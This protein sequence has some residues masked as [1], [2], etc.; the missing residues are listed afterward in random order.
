MS[1]IPDFLA[2]AGWGAARRAPLAG[3]ASARRYERLH[4]DG[5]SAV[6]MV[7]PPGAEFRRFAEIDDWLRAR[8]Y[9][10]PE[11]LAMEADAGLMLLEDLGDDLL[12]ALLTRSPAREAE[13]YGHVTDF[14]LDLHRHAPPGFVA[15]LDGPALGALVA[16]TADWAPGDPAAAAALPG[17]IAD[18]FAAQEALAPVLCLR[19][20]HAQNALWLPQRLGSARLGLLDFQDAVAGHP[21]YDLVSALQDVRRDVSPKVEALAR[22]AYCAARGLDPLSFGAAYALLGAQR[23]LR[24]H[25]V[26]ARLCLAMGKAAYVDLMPRNWRNLERN[27]AHP[28][29][30]V[31]AR[32]IRAA[33]P[34]PDA[35]M[36]EGLKRACGTRPTL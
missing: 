26:F 23:A 16:L 20:F 17:Q 30:A 8:G 12:S 31:L 13:L 28:A 18:L 22:Q 34:P 3:D 6:L 35:S 33:Y 2:Q 7:A 36:M 29:L 25:G 9:S 10:A 11:I 14:L 15:P 32:A 27:L 19:D 24:I 21:A 4:L 5:R 1:A